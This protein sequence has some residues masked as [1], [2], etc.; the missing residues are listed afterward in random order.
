MFQLTLKS[1]MI[2]PG[3]QFL[4]FFN[5]QSVDTSQLQTMSLKFFKLTCRHIGV[6]V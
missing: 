3:T 6:R 1:S 5:L 2:E 4:S